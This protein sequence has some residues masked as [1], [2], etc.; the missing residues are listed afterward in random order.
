MSEE[1]VQAQTEEAQEVIEELTQEAPDES[2]EQKDEVYEEKQVPLTALQKERKKRQDLE[3]EL[4]YIKQQSRKN[5]EED[6]SQYETATR[7]DLTK[8]QVEA[9]RMVEERLWMRQNPEKYEKINEDL[10]QFLKQRPHLAQAIAASP[11]RYEEAYL[12]MN[13][14]NPRERKVEAPK[15]QAKP[16]PGSPSSVPKGASLDQAVDVMNMTDS[17]FRGWRQ[18]LRRGR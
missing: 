18:S 6:I 11:N 15:A 12:L 9:V 10:P 1:P 2:Q 16:A 14:L 17:E 13:A 8:S 4:D 7:E 3:M 5:E